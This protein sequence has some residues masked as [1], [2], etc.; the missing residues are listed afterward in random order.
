VLDEA[1][2]LFIQNDEIRAVVNTG[3]T[4]L[5]DKTYAAISCRLQSPRDYSAGCPSIGGASRLGTAA[6][7]AR[8][9]GILAALLEEDGALT[10]NLAI[11]EI[12][13]NIRHAQCEL[14][15][16]QNELI[17]AHSRASALNTELNL[18]E[19]EL[20]NGPIEENRGW[21]QE[22]VERLAA[23]DSTGLTLQRNLTEALKPWVADAL[24]HIRPRRE[25]W[26]E[27]VRCIDGDG[28]VRIVY[29][30]RENVFTIEACDHADGTVTEV[31]RQ[32]TV[33]ADR[34][35]KTA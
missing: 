23:V 21:F 35:P 29:L 34:L 7:R 25:E 31:F 12:R 26:A 11:D 27:L 32:H 14:E 16:W 22:A 10:G 24:V 5:P 2:K 8:H 15:H 3:W 9:P 30:A 6:G 19:R 18:V 13:K 20:G 28:D 4:R 17:K 33:T 1:D